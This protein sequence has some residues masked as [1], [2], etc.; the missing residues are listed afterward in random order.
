MEKNWFKLLRELLI[1][2]PLHLKCKKKAHVPDNDAP[3]W[4]FGWHYDVWGEGKH[5]GKIIAFKQTGVAYVF[6]DKD[7]DLIHGNS[8]TSH[9]EIGRG[10]NFH[11][12]SYDPKG[13]ST[14]IGN[15]STGCVVV[16][17]AKDYYQMYNEVVNSGQ[18]VLTFCVI[19]GDI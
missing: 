4:D 8:G 15:W 9:K 5:K 19:S 13:S 12:A 18:T 16:Q 10:Q 11:P 1:Q 7:L 2:E 14:T 17:S 3:I 6:R